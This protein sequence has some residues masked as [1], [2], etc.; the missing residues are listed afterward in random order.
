MGTEPRSNDFTKSARKNWI[1][2]RSC[3]L[4]KW[5]NVITQIFCGTQV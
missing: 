2:K 4:P 3:G 5:C 1:M